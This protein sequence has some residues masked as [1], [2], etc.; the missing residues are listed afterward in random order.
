MNSNRM[1]IDTGA[2]RVQ[3]L[4][5][6]K[7][8]QVGANDPRIEYELIDCDRPL[9]AISDNEI[10]LRIYISTDKQ[11]CWDVDITKGEFFAED[12]GRKETTGQASDLANYAESLLSSLDHCGEAAAMLRYLDEIE[13]L[14]ASLRARISGVEPVKR[15]P[16]TFA[17][18]K[19]SARRWVLLRRV[20]DHVDGLRNMLYTQFDFEG[21]PQPYGDAKAAMRI[22]INELPEDQRAAHIPTTKP[23]KH[24]G[25]NP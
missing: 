23:E 10:I 25:I 8:K 4:G 2:P 7:A 6:L 11:G 16:Q 19:V 17:L 3:A 5:A 12:R 20:C 13:K 24:H 18:L 9:Q 22:A 21:G 1:G 14:A 15:G